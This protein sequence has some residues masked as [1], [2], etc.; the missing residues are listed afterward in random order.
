MS[1]LDE[2]TAEEISAV[3]QKVFDR[4]Y[5]RAKTVTPEMVASAY[6]R[7]RRNRR[8]NRIAKAGRKTNRK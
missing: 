7:K 4:V 8:R 5:G 6:K 1:N 2:M 3:K